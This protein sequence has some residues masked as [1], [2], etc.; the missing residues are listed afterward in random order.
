MGKK[1]Y[2]LR[3][4]RYSRSGALITRDPC[5]MV[6]VV[7]KSGAVIHLTPELFTSIYQFGQGE[8]KN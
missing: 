6:D 8:F 7:T 3:Q 1:V 4:R 2:K 5:G